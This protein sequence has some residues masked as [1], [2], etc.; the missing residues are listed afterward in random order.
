MT[1]SD[2][3]ARNTEDRA[4]HAI[5]EPEADGADDAREAPREDRAHDHHHD[6][7]QPER[8][9]LPRH[10]RDVDP[11]NMPES[12]PGIGDRRD[13]ADDPRRERDHLADD[14]ADEGEQRRQRDDGDDRDIESVHRRSLPAGS[15]MRA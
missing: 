5:H 14:P 6:Q 4:Q 15:D 12:V 9:R 8:Q 3:P 1:T 10:R 13:E 2:E 7:D 11:E